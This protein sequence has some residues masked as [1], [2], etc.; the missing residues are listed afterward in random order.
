MGYVSFREGSWH[1]AFQGADPSSSGFLT[2]DFQ[3][4]NRWEEGSG[5]CSKGMLQFSCERSCNIIS[6]T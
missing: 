3:I 4:I 5:V 1:F 6:N 2:C